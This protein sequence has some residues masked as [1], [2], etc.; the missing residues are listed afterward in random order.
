ME[1]SGGGGGGGG[2]E[3]SLLRSQIYNQSLCQFCMRGDQGPTVITKI[4]KLQRIS[5]K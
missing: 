4:T 5:H 3:G 1:L 2:G